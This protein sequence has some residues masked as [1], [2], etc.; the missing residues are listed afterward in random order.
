[1]SAF[2]VY[3]GLQKTFKYEMFQHGNS[4]ESE[5]H[6]FENKTPAQSNHEQDR[7]SDFQEEV[8]EEISHES[9]ETIS[10]ASMIVNNN[11]STPI[12]AK[13]DKD[14]LLFE[15]K[16]FRKDFKTLIEK[17]S[18]PLEKIANI[19]Q[20]YET[21]PQLLSRNLESQ[22]YYNKK[23]DIKQSKV[24]YHQIEDYEKI[25]DIYPFEIFLRDI[26]PNLESTSQKEYQRL[27][28]IA[29]HNEP[30]AYYLYKN[31]SLTIQIMKSFFK[32]K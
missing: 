1:M 15:I 27:Y 32:N 4:G 3:S 10:D 17:V 31:P 30:L 20:N 7:H 9:N 23:Q 12:E 2:I 16:E 29:D 19:L 28:K 5:N 14:E 11:I 26:L 25:R 13:S 22:P 24:T 8:K 18:V 6:S 21:T